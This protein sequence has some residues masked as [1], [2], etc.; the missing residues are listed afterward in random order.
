M[1][2]WVDASAPIGL[3]GAAVCELTDL[4]IDLDLR[5]FFPEET[6]DARLAQDCNKH[7]SA[8]PVT[9][10]WGQLNYTD[11]NVQLQMTREIEEVLASAHI[12]GHGVK[13]P[14]VWTAALAEWDQQSSTDPAC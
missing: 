8:W 5:D 2:S 14:L 7:F 11:P 13:T 9:V 3:L 6:V 4:K 12:A 1:S 10:H